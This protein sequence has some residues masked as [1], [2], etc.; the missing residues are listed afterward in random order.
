[1]QTRRPRASVLVHVSALVGYGLLAAL[2]SNAAWDFFGRHLGAFSRFVWTMR[3]FSVPW[4]TIE[5]TAIGAAAV[6]AGVV[7]FVRGAARMRL[8]VSGVD[9]LEGLRRE[10]PRALRVALVAVPAVL[11]SVPALGEQSGRWGWLAEDWRRW[12]GLAVW[13]TLTVV[14]PVHGVALIGHLLLRWLRS[15]LLDAQERA[16]IEAPERRADGFVFSAVAATPEARFAVGAF[17]AA[18]LVFSAAIAVDPAVPASP[19]TTTVLLVYGLIAAGVAAAYGR[20]SR[21]ALG[22]DGVRIGGT[23]RTRFFAYRDLD[24]VEE[25][26][27]EIVL[28]GRGRPVVRLQLHGRDAGLRAA[29]VE[30]LRAAIEAA[31]APV[32]GAARMLAESAPAALLSQAARGDGSYRAQGATRDQLWE[33]VETA[34]ADG[35]AR[36]RAARA[37]AERCPDED[38]ARLRAAAERCAEPETRAV[39]E[40]LA[41]AEA[42]AEEEH[43]VLARVA[44]APGRARA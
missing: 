34:N 22:F 24:G 41:E 33:I 17:A 27:H 1:M 14:L 13:T 26:G 43:A 39:L 29:V 42:E 2:Q 10:V 40:R 21:I 5:T 35:V 30:R 12:V 4:D 8:R 19:Q 44:S 20:A 32:R 6:M 25:R 31:R 3:Y 38:R 11:T 28:R 9:V 16:M 36:A 7:L 18:S 15:P 23:S 37:L